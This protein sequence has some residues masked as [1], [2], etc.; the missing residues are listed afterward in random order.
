MSVYYCKGCESFKDDDY[1]PMAESELCPDCESEL[2]EQLEME[3]ERREMRG[4]YLRDRMKDD[5]L[6]GDL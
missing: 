1:S 6:T 5:R 4:D 2:E 3:A